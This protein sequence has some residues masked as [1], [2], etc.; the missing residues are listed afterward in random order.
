MKFSEMSYTRPDMNEMKTA[1]EKAASGIAN[2]RSA[3]EAAEIYLDWDKT[4][5]SYSTM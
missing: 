3:E 2:A 4:S 5:G 1:A